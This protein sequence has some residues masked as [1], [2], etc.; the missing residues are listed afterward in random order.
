MAST[1]TSTSTTTKDSI[2]QKVLVLVQLA[3][4]KSIDL[5]QQGYYQVKMRMY[6]KLKRNSST[7]CQRIDASL[8]TIYPNNSKI[9][10][11]NSLSQDGQFASLKI[12]A[13]SC[14][15][16]HSICNW[17]C[18]ASKAYS[19]NPFSSLIDSLKSVTLDTDTDVDVSVSSECS[20]APL[21]YLSEPF[22]ISSVD[23]TIPLDSS[24]VFQFNQILKLYPT[25]GVLHD[26]IYMDFELFFDPDDER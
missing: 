22:Y 21:F 4:F 2:H 19:W 15:L 13:Y 17:R 11:N 16:G 9:Y 25:D 8:L 20:P 1:S 12:D 24:V 14:S 6:Q 10:L 3:D 18:K 26:D 7:T 5:F 23:D